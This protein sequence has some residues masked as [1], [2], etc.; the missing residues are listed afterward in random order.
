MKIGFL[1]LGKMGSGM[2]ACLAEAGHEVT[3]WNRSQGKAGDLL[4]LGAREAATPA[5]AAD[6]AEAVFS[7]VADDDA[8]SR[9]WLA[10]DG[11]AGAMPM[12]ALLIECSTISHAHSARLAEVATTRGLT[13]LDCPVNGPPAGARKGELVLLLGAADED[14]GRA[15]ALLEVISQSILHFGGT[16][17]GTAYKL[18]NNLLGAVHITAMAEAAVLAGKYGIDVDTMVEAIRTGPIAS[19]H[20]M[21][22][23]RPMLEGRSADT[24]ALSIGLREKDARYCIA[25]ADA[26]GVEMPVGASAHAWYSKSAKIHGDQD[27]SLIL[28][29]VAE[30]A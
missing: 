15:R 21:R 5:E 23:S 18:I 1:G 4:A 22:M 8:S 19:P 26:S 16:G 9:C 27:D 28:E 30:H 13:Y 14:L 25:M 29:T 12:G 2:A 24:F 11:A 7:M 17:T 20:T 10:E 6:G 3:V